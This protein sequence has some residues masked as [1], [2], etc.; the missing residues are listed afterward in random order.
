MSFISHIKQTVLPFFGLLAAAGIATSLIATPAQA[1]EAMPLTTVDQTYFFEFNYSGDEHHT[2]P[3]DKA[4]DTPSYINVDN[5]TIYDVYL[6]VDGYRN[7]YYYPN[8]TRGGQ[9]YLVDPGQW[10]IHNFVKEYGYNYASLR[11]VA[12]ESGVLGGQWSPDS[13]GTYNSLN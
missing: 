2:A 4:N 13:W 7:G 5:M 9:A 11:G 6:Y 3:V 8:T 1:G 10:W 12:Y